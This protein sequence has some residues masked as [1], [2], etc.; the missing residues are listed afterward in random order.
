MVQFP[1]N[2][3]TNKVKGRNKDLLD[4]LVDIIYVCNNVLTCGQNA[5]HII[6]QKKCTQNLKMKSH[7]KQF[8]G[9]ILN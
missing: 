1:K 8:G 5:E 6:N 9:E 7:E 2:L 3:I 4:M